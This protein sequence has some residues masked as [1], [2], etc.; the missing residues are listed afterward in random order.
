ML[1]CRNVDRLHAI[2]QA[3]H[4][5]RWIE[6]SKVVGTGNFWIPDGTTVDP[7]WQLQPFWKD[8]QSFYTSN[9]VHDTAVFGYAYP[10]TQ[11]W[12]YASQDEWRAAVNSSVAQLYSPSARAML[13]SNSASSGVDFTYL[14]KDDSFIDWTIKMK[15]SALHMPSTFRIVVSLTGDFSSDP[16]TEVGQWMKLMP[17]EHDNNPEWK[18]RQAEQ[19]AKRFSSLDQTLHGT[20]SLT[21]TLLDQIAARKL[22]GLDPSQVVPYLKDHLRWKVLGVFFTFSRWLGSKIIALGYPRNHNN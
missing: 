16:I 13:N 12:N 2:Y 8:G 19:K 3:V 9:D 5:D 1:Y 22:K 6:P 18:A 17:A 11:A 21:S 4:P 20:V 7:T 10:E 14:L 15:A